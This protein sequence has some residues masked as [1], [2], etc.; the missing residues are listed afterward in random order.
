MYD[1]N[2]AVDQDL[3]DRLILNLVFDV[4]TLTEDVEQV[5]MLVY[6]LARQRALVKED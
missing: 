1:A 6:D 5:K 2:D 3:T 4:T